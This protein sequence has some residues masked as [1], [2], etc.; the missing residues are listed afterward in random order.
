LEYE[1]PYA[2]W[3]KGSSK[4]WV[5]TFNSWK[6][7][8]GGPLDMRILGLVNTRISGKSHCENQKLVIPYMHD[9]SLIC[10]I[11]ITFAA[12]CLLIKY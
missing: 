12:V 5:L 1:A 6:Y 4:I 10:E 11:K 3:F 8:T 7:G 2:H 9:F